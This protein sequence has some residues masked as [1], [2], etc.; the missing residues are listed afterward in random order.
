MVLLIWRVE[1]VSQ[2]EY[3]SLLHVFRQFSW[4]VERDIMNPSIWFNKRGLLESATNTCSTDVLFP[5][6]QQ[7]GQQQLATSYVALMVLCLKSK[8]VYSIHPK[9]CAI[10]QFGQ[11][12]NYPFFLLDLSFSV[13]KLVVSLVVYVSSLQW[14]YHH[15]PPGPLNRKDH[16]TSHRHPLLFCSP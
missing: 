11:L 10:I 13:S 9:K 6:K 16:L 4:W 2:D 1:T 3:L 15:P 12:W 5:S 8:L 14:N 7:Q